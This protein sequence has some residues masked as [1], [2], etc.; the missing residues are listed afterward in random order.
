MCASV[1][2]AEA[3]QGKDDAMRSGIAACLPERRFA[4][5]SCNVDP[6][7]TRIVRQLKRIARATI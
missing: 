5:K 4:A 2:A 1:V 7:A 3:D 6:E